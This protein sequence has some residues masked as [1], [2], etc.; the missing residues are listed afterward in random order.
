M[1]WIFE[2]GTSDELVE[3]I[4][5]RTLPLA[6]FAAIQR[7]P[8]VRVT[9]PQDDEIAARVMTAAVPPQGGVQ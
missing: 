2:P 3:D 8:T 9:W 1:N 7:V 5:M 6:I 4:Y